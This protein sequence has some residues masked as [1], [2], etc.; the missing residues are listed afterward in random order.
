MNEAMQ[1]LRS[2]ANIAKRFTGLSPAVG[3]LRTPA[4]NGNDQP[5][6]VPRS[7]ARQRAM[8]AARDVAQARDAQ[9]CKPR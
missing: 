8:T 3:E 9:Q 5:K 7:A 2:R 1:R 6:M 4:S